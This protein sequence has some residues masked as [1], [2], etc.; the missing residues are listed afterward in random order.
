MQ[1]LS[2]KK[3]AISWGILFLIF[4]IVSP[5]VLYYSFGYR[6]DDLR[7]IIKTGGI[8]IHSDI[9]N[10]EIFVDGEYFKN[11]GVL[12]KNTLIQELDPETPHK[13]EVRKDGYYNW[14]K[15]LTVRE[16]LVTESASM[17]MPKDIEANEILPYVTKDGV[18]T[19]TS[20]IQGIK[21]A[22]NSE[23]LKV[24]KLFAPAVVTPPIK[25]S[26]ATTTKEIPKYFTE[27]NISDSDKLDNLI[28]RGEEVAWVE[29]GD[30]VIHWIGEKDA[31]PFY[32]CKNEIC[33]SE[34]KLDWKNDIARFDF[35]PNRDHVLVVLGVDGIWAV[36]IDDR[37]E[38]NIQPI[39]VGNKLDFRIN[40][41][42]RIV[43]LQ[44]GSFFELRF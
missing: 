36:E 22:K 33:E 31:F 7:G 29:N 44:N 24:E 26:V 3:R 18:A 11:N 14:N 41:N 34:K 21:L 40:E 27:L 10:T 8:Y 4:L 15:V 17:M 12:I 39:F 20:M 6:F 37:S 42:N 28:V 35:L 5:L 23:Y 43:V 30:V 13:I 1:P 19:S 32:Y 16:G 9:A 2:K 25:G 38:R